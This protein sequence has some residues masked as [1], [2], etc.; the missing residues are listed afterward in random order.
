[1][2][3]KHQLRSDPKGLI[4][5]SYRIKDI[6]SSECRTIFLDWALSL[7]SNISSDFAL[8][9]LLVKYEQDYSSHPM[10]ELLRAGMHAKLPLKHRQ[11]RSE[12]KRSRG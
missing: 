12:R 5:E 2:S 4:Y 8:R 1:M 7:P 11:R 6:S 3:N 10:T 9:E